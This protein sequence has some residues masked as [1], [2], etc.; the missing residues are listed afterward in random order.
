MKNT[1]KPQDILD[2]VNRY[3][4]KQHDRIQE[5]INQLTALIR[6]ARSIISQLKQDPAYRY[7]NIPF[8][9]VGP[10]DTVPVYT[11]PYGCDNCPLQDFAEPD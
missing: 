5:Q 9:N 7:G 6:T 11:P 10:V 1:S 4:Q 3:G 2:K 8:R